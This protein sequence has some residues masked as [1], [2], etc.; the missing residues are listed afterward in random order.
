M[1]IMT[2]SFAWKNKLSKR[3]STTKIILHHAAAKSADVQTV[4]KWH[5][6]NGWSGIGYHFYVRKSGEVWQGRPIDAVG[7][8]TY[9]ENSDSIGICFEG[10]FENEQMDKAQIKAGKELIAHILLKYPN[11]KIYG[12]NDFNAT[13][14]PGKNFPWDEF[15]GKGDT[16]NTIKRGSKGTDVK[17]LQ[18]LLNASG[19]N[20]TVDGD[21]GSGTD[22]AVKTF[23]RSKNLTADGI[24]GAKTWEALSNV[25]TTSYTAEMIVLKN[26]IANALKALT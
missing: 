12:H 7:S 1:E 4:H 10:N 14:C 8:H 19:E 22:A 24:V 15:N 11:L 21:F 13:A 25:K 18:A 2:I 5:L 3:K 16:V 20:L 6:A 17:I 26:K 23:Q 9:G